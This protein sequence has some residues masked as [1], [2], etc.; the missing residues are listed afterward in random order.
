[1][2]LQ[3][4]MDCLTKENNRLKTERNI[5]YVVAAAA[6]GFAVARK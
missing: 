3:E 6:I 1:M 2:K 4:Q 5:A